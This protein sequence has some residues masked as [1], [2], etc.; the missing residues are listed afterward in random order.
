M[1]VRGRARSPSL[2]NPSALPDFC[3]CSPFAIFTCWY[4]PALGT[5][6]DISD[7]VPQRKR[8][9]RRWC[10]WWLQGQEARGPELCFFLLFSLKGDLRWSDP[11]RFLPKTYHLHTTVSAISTE[12]DVWK[13][14]RNKKH[15]NFQFIP[16]RNWSRSLKLFFF[17]KFF[18]FFPECWKQSAVLWWV[19]GVW[20]TDSKGV[21]P[22]RKTG[23][24]CC[25]SPH[26]ASGLWSNN[27][28]FWKEEKQL[29]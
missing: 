17:F 6:W 1:W 20:C 2:C 8:R 15:G 14:I 11:P 16:R 28:V 12:Q 7:S 25:L 23:T 3:V 19:D 24:V 22:L 27:F 9:R 10:R 29:K 18:F 21:S 26:G 13:A 4:K 5:S